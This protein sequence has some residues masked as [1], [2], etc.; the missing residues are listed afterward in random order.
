M[1]HHQALRNINN[2]RL[3]QAEQEIVPLEAISACIDA[4]IQ[5]EVD[6]CAS[7]IRQVCTQGG[8]RSP[9]CKPVANSQPPYP[10]F[11][12]YDFIELGKGTQYIDWEPL[13]PTGLASAG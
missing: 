1:Q 10:R 8:D 3:K 12:K 6:Q 9:N 2:I 5:R 11:G 4:L 7:V 13:P